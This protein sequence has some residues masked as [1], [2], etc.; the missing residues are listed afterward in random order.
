MIRVVF[1]YDPK[2]ESITFRCGYR[3][4]EGKLHSLYNEQ[5][6][7]PSQGKREGGERREGVV[8]SEIRMK[9]LLSMKFYF[10]SK[11]VG[12][13][14]RIKSDRGN[15]HVQIGNCSTNVLSY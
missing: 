6:G 10:K 1:Y 15:E 2:K 9:Y 11:I 14:C 3:T 5:M 7:T 8:E 4:A 13:E 12:I